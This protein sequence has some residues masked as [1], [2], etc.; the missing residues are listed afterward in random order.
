MSVSLVVP[1]F[2][3]WENVRRLYDAVT[4]VLSRLGRPYEIIFVDDGSTDGSQR[5]LELIADADRRVRVIEFR[6]NFGQT[7]ALAAGFAAATGDVIV[8]M[9]GDLQNDPRDIPMLL[10]KLDEGNDLVHGWRRDRKDALFRRRMP[11]R[12][13]NCVIARTTGYRAHDLGCGLKAMR[14][15]IANDLRLS[16]EMHR[17]LPVLAHARG[18]KCA[19][20][21]TRHHP[22]KFGES[23]YGLSR[24]L[25][26]LF[27]LI[28]VKLLLGK[29]VSP[30]R[31]FGTLGLACACTGL[32]A[33][34]LAVMLAAI[35][36]IPLLTNPL[37]A[38][39]VVSLLLSMQ[40]IGLGLL[41]E[42]A[43]RIYLHNDPGRQFVVRKTRNLDD[44][45]ERPSVR[46]H[47]NAAA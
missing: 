8:T 40:S 23:K 27:D 22:R 17:F 14:R 21:V 11:S 5:E 10:D 34:G 19:E 20:V 26:V 29:I 3:E 46:L 18:A 39:S 35:H 36:S 24:T 43:V 47:H 28:T 4:P 25:R 16:G 31:F 42:V 45:G 41:G 6:R 15:E 37:S 33:G 1:I 12:I 32:F 2:N 9:D 44:E 13:A 38:L 30:M 7:A